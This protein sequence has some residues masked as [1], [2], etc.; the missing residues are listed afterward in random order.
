[1]P[2]PPSIVARLSD[3][4]TVVGEPTPAPNGFEG[5]WGGCSASSRI[6]AS[7]V[8]VSRYAPKQKRANVAA[9]VTSIIT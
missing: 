7:Q 1:M 4:E 8:G 6:S 3:G 5:G 2:F 9:N